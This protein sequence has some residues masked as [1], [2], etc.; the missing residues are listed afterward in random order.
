MCDM[1]STYSTIYFI[2]DRFTKPLKFHF[3]RT[4]LCC[5]EMRQ[6][7]AILNTEVCLLEEKIVMKL[8]FA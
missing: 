2:G 8:H 4:W 1:H 3:I 5:V 7:R 6:K